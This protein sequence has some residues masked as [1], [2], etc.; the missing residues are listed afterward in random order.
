[1]LTHILGQNQDPASKPDLLKLNPKHVSLWYCPQHPLTLVENLV[2]KSLCKLRE[3]EAGGLVTG[4][5]Y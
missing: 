4:E 3:Q 2:L 5:R 1:M